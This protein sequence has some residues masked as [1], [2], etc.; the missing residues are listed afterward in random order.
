MKAAGKDYTPLSVFD[1]SILQ[2]TD[3]FG[4]AP[5][6]TTLTVKYR[7]N[8]TDNT[9][10]SVGAVNNVSFVDILFEDETVLDPKKV[11]Y[12]KSSITVKNE[13]P[14]NGQKIEFTSKE[15]ATNILAKMGSQGRCVTARDYVAAAYLMPSKFGK[16]IRASVDTD[17]NDLRRSLNMFVISQDRFGRLQ[18][19][20]TPLKQNLK[21]WINSVKMMSDSI[22]IFDA[23]ILNLG[24]FFDV[25]LNRNFDYAS[26]TAEIRDKLFEKL[27][28]V[29]PQIGQAFPIGEVTKILSSMKMINRVNSV[30][31]KNKSG[32]NYSNNRM[33]LLRNK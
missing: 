30:K 24:L 5:Q 11:S 7:A 29:F 18:T 10:A 17:K 2:T 8:T 25:A 9:N 31:V 14:I 1:P 28:A 26:A 12:I 4:I 19:A 6:N 23:K 27:T 20:S 22:D 16:V 21:T 33:M 15:R 13:E 3:K 32:E